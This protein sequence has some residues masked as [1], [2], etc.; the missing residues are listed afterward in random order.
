MKKSR[1]RTAGLVV[2]VILA[3]LLTAGVWYT[4]DYYHASEEASFYLSSG[5]AVTG[6]KYI[7]V[8]YT[9]DLVPPGYYYFGEDG[10]MI[11]DG[12]SAASAPAA[13]LR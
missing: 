4:A 8:N 12:D 13:L 10:R 7:T 6:K 11:R 3:A 2:L 9:N 1:G 5:K